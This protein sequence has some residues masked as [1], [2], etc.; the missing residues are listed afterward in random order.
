MCA[1]NL[2]SYVIIRLFQNEKNIVGILNSN[3]E[4]RDRKTGKNLWLLRFLRQVSFISLN[5]GSN[6]YYD[7]RVK[8]E[9][10]IKEVIL[11][12]RNNEEFDST[13]FQTKHKTS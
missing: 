4:S 7:T 1:T 11:V 8:V 13:E 10:E 2:I 6:P 12:S 9:P 3:W 5:L